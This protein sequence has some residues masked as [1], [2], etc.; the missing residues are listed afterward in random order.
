M[1]VAVMGAGAVGCYYGGMLAR[2]GHAVVLIG[3]PQ[4]V[5]AVCRDGLFMHTQSF[6]AQVPMQASTD[7]GAVRGAQLVL[8]C[9]KSPDT[10]TAAM[11]MAP[12]LDPDACLLSLQNGVDNAERW[13]AVLRREVAP[14]V[15]YVATEM[16]GPGFV[17]HHGRGELVIGPSSCSDELLALF[18]AAAIPVTISDNVAGA[19]WAKL[20][21]NCVYNA[22]SAI[23][24][25][26]YGH[27]VQGDGVP[28]VMRDVMAECLAVAQAAGVVVAGDM[29]QA[30]QQIAHTMPGQLSS[31]AQ[32]LARHKPSEIDHL[33]GYVLRKGEALAVP[34]PVNRVLYALVKLL[35]S[36]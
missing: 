28:G 20:I 26:P 36:R 9:V 8:C 30:V 34:T 5:A 21:V 27:L 35:E 16:A 4:H 10:E 25:L 32:D 23:T 2:A 31:T 19:L 24:Q 3:R 29:W 18:A 12:H 11:A 14:A 6:Q 1:K 15:V 17:K 22:V 13:Q 33:N 7:A